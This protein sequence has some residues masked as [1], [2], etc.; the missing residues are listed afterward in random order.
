MRENI[1]HRSVLAYTGARLR[2][3]RG[4]GGV[5]VAT[6]W[7]ACTAAEMSKPQRTAQYTHTLSLDSLRTWLYE[8]GSSSVP[9]HR[10]G[11][12][13][14]WCTMPATARGGFWSC[15]CTVLL[16][17]LTL[18]YGARGVPP[19]SSHRSIGRRRVAIGE[20]GSNDE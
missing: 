20:S 4:S 6:R 5:R 14:E 9:L 13:S 17:Q 18:S 11:W 1:C 10:S 15:V 3:L 8:T 16:K 12:H 7:S 19:S 2:D